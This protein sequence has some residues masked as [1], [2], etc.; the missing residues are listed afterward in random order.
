[1]VHGE[2]EHGHGPITS[3]YFEISYGHER[4]AWSITSA[5]NQNS[6][7]GYRD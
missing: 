1:M 6:Y 7:R 3:Q 4:G 5:E 2:F